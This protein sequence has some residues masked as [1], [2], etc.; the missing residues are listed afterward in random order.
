MVA[1][2]D[3]NAVEATETVRLTVTTGTGYT[4]GSPVSAGDGEMRRCT[5]RRRL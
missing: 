4:V 1:A 2:V 3:D 5:T